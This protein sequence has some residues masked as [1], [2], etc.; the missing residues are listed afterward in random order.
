MC[1]YCGCNMKLVAR[2]APVADY[3]A[4][5]IAEI[6]VLAAALP[7]RMPVAHVHFGGGTP[8]ALSTDDL[9]A[10]MQHLNDRF[11][12][13]ADTERAIESDPP[14]LTQRM[15]ETIRRPGINRATFVAHDLSA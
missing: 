14:T 15:V 13:T 11:Y 1:W 9:A 6:N 5:L 7:A 8:T 12:L 4:H 10:V 2:Y 3:V